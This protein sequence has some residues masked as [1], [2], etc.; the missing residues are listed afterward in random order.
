[1]RGAIKD[2]RSRTKV[3]SQVKTYERNADVSGKH[4]WRVTFTLFANKVS[5]SGRASRIREWHAATRTTALL[6]TN[7][8]YIGTVLSFRGYTAAQTRV[9]NF[10]NSST[11]WR[12]QVICLVLLFQ[13]KQKR[14]NDR[15]E[16][17]DKHVCCT[18]YRR[19]PGRAD[20]R[21]TRAKV[22]GPLMMRDTDG[23]KN[24]TDGLCQMSQRCIVVICR[25][26]SLEPGLCK[27]SPIKRH[28]LA[29]GDAITIT[30]V[31]F[32]HVA[33]NFLARNCIPTRISRVE[34]TKLNVP[35]N[36]ARE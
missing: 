16:S 8:Q 11:R 27:G 9:D 14:R 32:L 13:R 30:A 18:N 25:F 4:R 24:R 33:G 26:S 21:R 15:E 6:F 17:I 31:L 12:A 35:W 19:G 2:P 7:A 22:W 1:M 29:I 10:R 28:A 34:I 36:R 5:Y 23:D 3:N 20:L